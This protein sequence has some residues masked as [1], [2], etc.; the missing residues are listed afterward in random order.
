MEENRIVLAAD[1]HGQV[2]Q[3][4]ENTPLWKRIWNKVID[5]FCEIPGHN[6]AFGLVVG[7][8]VFQVLRETGWINFH[9]MVEYFT[10]NLAELHKGNLW[11]MILS[12]FAHNRW[13]SLIFSAAGLLLT[14]S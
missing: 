5:W 6:I 9:E 13:D 10:F 2:V 4:R 14:C 1:A 12:P 3:I 11:G 7:G 8:V